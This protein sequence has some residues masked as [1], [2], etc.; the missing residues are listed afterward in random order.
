MDSFRSLLTR[1]RQ[2]KLGL[3]EVVAMGVGGMVSGG[4]YAVLGVAMRQAGNAVPLSYLIAGILTLV[5]AYSY[6]KLTLHFGEHGGVFS[7]VEHIVDSPSLAAYVGWVLVVGYVGVMAMYAFAFGAYT[8]T[9]ARAI[10]GFE[11]P[12]LLRPV[13][14]VLIVAVFVGLNLRGVEET[15]LFEDI[16]VY[17]KI[18]I[19]LSLAVLGIVFYNG[20]VTSV[21]FFNKGVVSPITGFAI[22]FVSYEG[23]QLLVYD[24]EDIADVEQ[25]L[26]VGMYIAIA[27]AIAIYVSVSFMVTLH[28]TPEQ[29]VAHEEVALAEAVSNIPLLGGAGFV[30]VI[31]SAMKSTS[32]G[33]NA[34]L[35]GTARLVHKIATEGALPRVFSFRNREGIPV[36][37]LVIMGSLTAAFAA[38]G[39][40]KQITEF[41]S[42]AFL[43]SFAVTNYTN[44]RLADE[45]GSIRFLPALGLIGTTVAIPV[46][47]YHLYR[48]DVEI[49][50]WIVGIFVSLFLLE[51]LYL[52][53]SPFDP[54]IDGD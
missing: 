35:F 31:L 8:L 53:R 34:T 11:L 52:Q 29:L 32:S 49:L 24:Y 12:Q 4:I 6:L 39:S 13:I 20:S 45:T 16:A 44:L 51:F 22:I 15:G 40:L 7:F 33:I 17:I 21:H 36:Y 38:L 2:G 47:L 9:A 41:G 30:L 46:V 25:V 19:L 26:P 3:L 37:A 50:L 48:T 5:T 10:A 18:T 14:S 23:F 43:A 1:N 27:I 42:V 28:L 54:A